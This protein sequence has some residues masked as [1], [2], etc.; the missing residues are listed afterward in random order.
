MTPRIVIAE[1]PRAGSGPAA[2]RVAQLEQA[3]FDAGRRVVRANEP[4]AIRQAIVDAQLC[5][6]LEAVVA[7]GG[8]GTVSMIAD[9]LDPVTPFA[10]LPIG[11]ENL[12]ARHFGFPNDPL[13]LARRVL[14][15]ERKRFDAGLANGKLF[16]VMASI[17]F[18]ADVVDDFHRNR[19]GHIR[20]WAYFPPFFRTLRRYRYP[21]LNIVTDN[22]QT[23][24]RVRWAW[25]FNVPRYALRLKFLPDAVVDDGRLDLGTFRDGRFWKGLVYFLGVVTQTHTR[26]DD[27][28]C[29]RACRIEITSDDTVP[30]QIDGDPGGVLP[31]TIE[32]LPGRLTV[33]G[34][35]P[36]S[37]LRS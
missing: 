31:L 4:N 34:P 7:A 1:N 10:I 2:V 17:G 26:W 23:P 35:V 21:W 27:W 33:I 9:W 24:L 32:V 36:K 3:L 30:Y 18:D 28:H 13:Q 8:D 37:D 12:L 29:E 6:D 20:Q 22:H 11:T 25:V 16:L 19:T 5:G 14:D 15:G